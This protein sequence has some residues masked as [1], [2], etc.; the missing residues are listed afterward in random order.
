[1][2]TCCK[3]TL[4]SKRITVDVSL[5]RVINLSRTNKK[6]QCKE[7]HNVPAV[8]EILRHNTHTH[9]HPITYYF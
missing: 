9:T 3:G 6:L 4:I 2:G 1:M 5:G 7:N 8:N